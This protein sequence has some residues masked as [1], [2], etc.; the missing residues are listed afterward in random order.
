MELYGL[1]G[2]SPVGNREINLILSNV[3]PL[4]SKHESG[5]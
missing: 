2:K 1:L 3:N 5:K 4:P